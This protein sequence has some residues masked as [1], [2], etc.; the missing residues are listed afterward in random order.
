MTV[1]TSAATPEIDGA[2]AAERLGISAHSD[3]AFTP[4]QT[5]SERFASVDV[6]AFEAVTGREIAWKLTPVA[7]LGDLIDGVL[8]GSPAPLEHTPVDGVDVS[9]VGR[10]DQRIGTAGLPEDRAAANAWS[11]FEKA[12]AVRVTGEDEKVATLVRS[13]LGSAPRAA[14][15]IIE[16]APYARAVVVLQNEGEASLAENVE[17]LVGEGAQLTVVTVQEWADDARHLANHFVRVGRDAKV[18]HIVVTLGGSIVRVNP[19]AHLVERGADGELFGLYFADGGQHLE[20]QVYVD[21]DAPDTRSRVTYKGA[22]QGEGARTVWIGDVLIRNSATGTD[23]YEQNRNLVL[24]DGTRADSIPN[25]EIETGDIAGAGH[26]SATGRFDDEQ[27]FYLQS[28][29]IRED[30]ARRLVV[31]GFLSEIVQQIKVAELEDRLQ[32]AIEAELAGSAGQTG[33]SRGA[34]VPA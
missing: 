1:P 24:S 29:G 7:R 11:S 21:H 19:S 15:T 14:H 4:V 10:D 5:R 18:K 13:G 8:D 20:Q 26:A 3:G 30:E 2:A 17:I 12:L 32:L 33:S 16:A 34:A 23:S 6:E 22:L 31:R 27:L 9:W 25:L 28:R